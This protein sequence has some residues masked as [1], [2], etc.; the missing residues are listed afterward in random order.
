MNIRRMTVEEFFAEA[1]EKFGTDKGNWKFICP[2]CG[3][4]ASVAEWKAAGGESGAGFSCIGRWIGAKIQAFEKGEGPCNY[5][6]GGLICISPVEVIGH[7]RF[8]EFAQV[9]HVRSE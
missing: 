4:V 2:S 8:F 5:A 9:D 6:G 7:G 1:V 3:H